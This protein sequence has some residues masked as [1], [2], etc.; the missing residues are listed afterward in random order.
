MILAIARKE[1]V[2]AWRDGR[3][4]WAAGVSVLLFLVALLLGAAHERRARAE[5]ETAARLE[6]ETWLEQGEKNAHSA[7]H[8]GIHVFK[9]VAPLAAFE[10]GIEPYVGTTVFLEAHRQNHAAFLPAQD[11]SAMR[12]FGE[13][14]AANGLQLLAPLLVVLLAFGSLAGERERGTLRQTLSLGVRA[15]TLVLGKA[16]GLGAALALVLAPVALVGAWVLLRGPGAEE[17]GTRARLVTLGGA[18][19]VYLAGALGLCLL[20]SGLAGSARAALAT[21]LAC[22]AANAVVAPRLAADLVRHLQPLPELSEFQAALQRDLAQGID[23]HDLRSARVAALAERTMREHGVK[24]LEDLPFNFQGLAMIESERLA[25]EIHDRHFGALWDR[26]EAQDRSVTLAGLATPLLALRSA[27]MAL[28]GTDF[29][30]HRA[31][32]QAAEEHRRKL[33][34]VLNE[35]LMRA[36]DPHAPAGR[37]LWERLPEFTH[38]LRSFPA[39]L[40]SAAAGLAILVLWSAAVWGALLLL[41]PR[42]E[43]RA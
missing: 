18:Y 23:G 5:R 31:F 9:P 6:R 36:K 7:G 2:D 3:M 39:A 33:V 22:W 8:Q 32:A 37:E 38:A 13:L 40:R 15:R 24:R 1:L 10:R 41:A 35:E 14:T 20:V 11:A 30:H 4:R 16:L 21:L 25:D 26:L 12:R 19:A 27:S 34:L 17:P 43:A 28:A 42:L 29:T